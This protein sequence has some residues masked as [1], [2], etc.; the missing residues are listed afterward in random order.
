M[1]RRMQPKEIEVVSDIWL[2]GNLEAHSFVKKNYWINNLNSVKEQFKEADIY[3]FVDNEQIMGFAGL[4]KNYLAAIFVKKEYQNHGV[5][6]KLLDYLKREYS[7]LSLDVYDKNIQAKNFY[8]QNNFKVIHENID[9][10]TNEVEYQMSW[11]GE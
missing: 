10:S 11:K 2:Q 3:V 6:R 8:L 5:G 9:K 1:I 7:E 4:Q